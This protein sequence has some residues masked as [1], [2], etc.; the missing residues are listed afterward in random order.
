MKYFTLL[1]LFIFNVNL[2]SSDYIGTSASNQPYILFTYTFSN[3]SLGPADGIERAKVLMQNGTV[4]SVWNLKTG[5]EDRNILGF[6]TL[7]DTIKGNS[8]QA[9]K[10]EYDSNNFPKKIEP[11]IDK[12]RVGGW[13]SIEIDDLK[14]IDDMDH[15]IDIRQERMDEFRAN[16]Q[17]WMKLDAKNYSFIYQDSRKNDVHLEGVGVTIKNERVVKARDIRSYQSIAQLENQSFFTLRELFAIVKKRLENNQQITVLYAETYG[18]PYWIVFKDN[19]G[20][21]RTI[22]SRNFKKEF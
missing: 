17:K 18:Y 5:L 11:K 16:H 20:S 19:D 15:T 22:F 12:E 1:Y 14:S 9:L 3:P 7:I 10:V 2:L 6:K 4:L 13:Y 8:S 21:L